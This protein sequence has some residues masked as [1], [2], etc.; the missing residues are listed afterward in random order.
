MEAA[1]QQREDTRR[2]LRVEPHDD[3]AVK[4]AGKNLWKMR[5]GDMPSFFWAFVRKIGTRV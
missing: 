3:E 1:W 2:R 4:M 5:K